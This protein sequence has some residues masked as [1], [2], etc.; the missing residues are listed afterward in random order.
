LFGLEALHCLHDLCR[1]IHSVHPLLILLLV[2]LLVS[3]PVLRPSQPHA[4]LLILRF[5]DQQILVFL[6]QRRL[7]K[8][9]SLQQKLLNDAALVH[10]LSVGCLL[11]HFKCD[12][13]HWLHSEGIATESRRFLDLISLCDDGVAALRSGGA[14]VYL[15]LLHGLF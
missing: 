3:E 6:L 9:G 11:Y 10:T 7:H 1:E 14:V 5:A 15:E 2:H 8:V 4:H 12:F 13:R